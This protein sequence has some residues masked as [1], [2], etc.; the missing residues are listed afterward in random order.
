MTQP[1]DFSQPQRIPLVPALDSRSFD[2]SKDAIL[3]NCIAEKQEAVGGYKINKR[4]G[5]GP[6]LYAGPVGTIK[7]CGV[8]Y[9]NPTVLTYSV[10]AVGTNYALYQNGV[11]VLNASFIGSPSPPGVSLPILWDFEEMS[12]FLVLGPVYGSAN[13]YAIPNSSGIPALI[14]DADFLSIS[15]VKGFA[16]LNGRL[17]VMDFLGRIYGSD[18]DNPLSWTATNVIQA[19]SQPD[20]GVAVVKHLSYI[21]AFKEWSLEF[22]SD[23]GAPAP[24]SVLALVPGLQKS[25]GCIASDTIR[26]LDG[27]LF[28]V[29]SNRSRAPQ[30]VR[31]VNAQIQII[32]TPA[33]EKVLS[34]LN[35][36][37][38]A[39]M[40]LTGVCFKASG[41][42][43]YM[44]NLPV[45]LSLPAGSLVYDISEDLWYFWT[46]YNQFSRLQESMNYAS[47]TFNNNGKYFQ[48][49][50]T[51]DIVPYASD[52]VYVKDTVG[53]IEADI[54]TSNIE[55]G[56][57]RWKVLSRL[58]FGIDEQAG[59]DLLVR[60]NDHDYT[61]DKWS[62]YRSVSLNQSEPFL[63]N[64]GRFKRRAYH[65]RHTQPTKMRIAY[66][67]MQLSLG[68]I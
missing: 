18:L 17:Y 16:Y 20:F 65:F 12:G 49:T 36:S 68:A 23:V 50:L 27:E 10:V 26:G 54:I 19:R 43:F 9:S 34:T 48:N 57:K 44:I 37:I 33:V 52:D 58:S 51:G 32:S 53:N 14:T 59:S 55:L 67:D 29:S 11:F 66:V 2:L 63:Q 61:P 8:Y 64:E 3:K 38:T 31:M 1:I 15:R 13:C 28:W 21:V 5:T 4:F 60:Y 42:S 35:T 41:H 6:I 25:Y 56:T 46:K 39:I 24:G 47:E 45:G 7:G 30:V 40:K 62:Q 22:F